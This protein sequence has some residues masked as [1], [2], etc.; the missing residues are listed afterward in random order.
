MAM[1]AVSAT[2]SRSPPRHPGQVGRPER[3]EQYA[4]VAGQ[5]VARAPSEEIAGGGRARDEPRDH[6]HDPRR[7]EQGFEHLPQPGD[8]QADP[9]R[10]SGPAA[11]HRSAPDSTH[12]RGPTD[13][14]DEPPRRPR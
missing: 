11:S 6:R 10:P 12:A 14:P 7:A 3:R 1:P 13:H 8:E 2:G 4:G 5:V 9:R